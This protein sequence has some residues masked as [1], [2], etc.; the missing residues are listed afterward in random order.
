MRRTSL[1][2]RAD[3]EAA[4]KTWAKMSV[5]GLAAL[6]ALPPVVVAKN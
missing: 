5:D 1:S 3:F 4:F 2:N 6:K